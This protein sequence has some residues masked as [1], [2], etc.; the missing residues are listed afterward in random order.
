MKKITHIL[1]TFVAIA[2]VMALAACSSDDNYEWAS[3]VP[4]DNPGAYFAAS[5]TASSLLTPDEYASNPDVKLTVKRTNA[6]GRLAV[7]IIVD[8]AD[9]VF[10]IPDSAVFE[11]GKAETTITV[12][13]SGVKTQTTYRFTIHLAEAMTN[14][15]AETDGSPVFN[16][17]VLVARWVKIVDA[18]QFVWYKSEFASSKSDIYWLEGQNR[19]RISNW[20]GSGIDLQFCIVAQD[21]EDSSSYSLD[22]FNANDRSTWHGSFQPYNHYL[23]DPYGGSY[24][25][26]MNDSET[27]DY[28]SWY[29]DGE[30]KL[31]IN[32]VNFYYD[33]T[34]ETY[35][36]IDLRGSSS[37][38]SLY[39]VPYV[40]YTDGTQSGYTYLFGYWNGMLD[41]E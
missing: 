31:G 19:F 24:W 29:P 4:A 15:Y 39:L 5:N 22:N 11:D 25:Y 20:L 18:A 40:Y 8:K 23:M 37:T 7:P 12:K 30:D 32:Y 35:A 21:K 41:N 28:A 38:Y 3:K 14:P 16:Y 36:S 9:S 1:Y 34:S 27:E 33:I 13:S 10:A 6:N 17:E 2:S 26:L